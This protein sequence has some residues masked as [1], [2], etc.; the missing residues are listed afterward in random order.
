MAPSVDVVEDFVD[1]IHRVI[2]AGYAQGVY[3]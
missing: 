3:S 2:P 1:R